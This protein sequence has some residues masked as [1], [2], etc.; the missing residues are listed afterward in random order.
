MWYMLVLSNLYVVFLIFNC[1]WICLHM[2]C[3]AVY[4]VDDG[5]NIEQGMK[6]KWQHIWQLNNKAFVSFRRGKKLYSL[7][8]NEYIFIAFSD[9]ASAGWAV[10]HMHSGWT[11]N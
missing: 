6:Q 2:S 7:L 3:K 5:I 4:T 1:V 8:V 11:E 10:S 9:Y